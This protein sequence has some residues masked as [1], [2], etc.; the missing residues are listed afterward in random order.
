MTTL[1]QASAQWYSRPDDERFTSLTEMQ[2]HF[3]ALRARS[4]EATVNTHTIH[5][6]ADEDN[7]GLKIVGE[8]GVGYTPT[9]WA[10][11]QLCYLARPAP[12]QYLRELPSSL[13]A[14][15]INY[16]LYSKSAQDTKL[17]LDKEIGLR[18]ATGAG[19]G[20]I[21]NADVIDSLVE[22][23]GDGATGRFKVP[24]EFGRDVPITKANTTLYAGDRDMFVFLADEKNRIELPNRRDGKTGA[25][26]RGFFL[27]QSE[28]GACSLNVKSFLFDYVCMNRIVWGAEEIQ[29]ISIRHT[30]AAPDRFLR[31][32]APALTAYADSSVAGIQSALLAAQKQKLENVEA[33]LEKRFG[34]KM[35]ERIQ[36]AH[37]ADEQRPVE[38]LW[39]AVTAVTALARTVPWQMERV[40]LETQAGDLLKLVA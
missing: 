13:A 24:G 23:F 6:L 18:A 35:V 4:K 29:E 39:D 16:G 36:Q 40:A 25:L 11:N 19:Y 34:A 21:W 2:K 22:R 31:E 30:S 32:I 38:T 3:A 10:F 27:W 7:K 5:A 37:Q 14:D 15:L 17:L 26:A 33:F 20:R 8:A 9:H 28:V 1:T 12:A